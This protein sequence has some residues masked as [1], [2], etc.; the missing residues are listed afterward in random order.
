MTL[1][2]PFLT[3]K[4]VPMLRVIDLLYAPRQ[5]HISC[6]ARTSYPPLHEVLGNRASLVMDLLRDPAHA[7]IR[8]SCRQTVRA[9]TVLI[10]VAAAPFR[11]PRSRNN[12]HV[13]ADLLPSV[14][15]P[16]ATTERL[17]AAPVHHL[18]VA[19]ALILP[20]NGRNLILLEIPHA[21]TNECLGS[22]GSVQAKRI[23]SLAS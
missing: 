7:H 13:L 19:L 3:I 8:P 22:G 16:F 23:W 5:S 10:S 1:L 17:M 9:H 2:F 14:H 12:N 6:Q 11:T 4:T 18:M 15:T 21:R 20:L